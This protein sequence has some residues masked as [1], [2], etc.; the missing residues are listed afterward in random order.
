MSYFFDTSAL[1]KVYHQE[2]HSQSVLNIFN[3]NEDIYLSEL[4]II[5][6]H[7]V[8][9][10]KFKEKLLEKEDVERIIRRFDADLSKRFQLLIFNAEVIESAREI[11]EYLEEDLLVR[12]L[13]VIQIGFFKSYLKESDSFMTFDLRQKTA[14]EK[15]KSKNFF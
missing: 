6:Y 12:T 14:V 8:I 10:R 3:T 9:Y 13:D 11:F 4:A 7:S 2:E 15:L 5:E 1:A